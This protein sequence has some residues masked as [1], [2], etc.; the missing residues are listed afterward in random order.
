MSK[1]YE[2]LQR[3]EQDR[4]AL[5]GTASAETPAPAPAIPAQSSDPEALYQSQT[6]PA[7]QPAAAGVHTAALPV[8]APS[9]IQAHPQ[10]V[11][12][13]I[14][15]DIVPTP[16]TPQL[17]KLPALRERG[18][19]VE[20][21]RS[22]RTRL[23]AF[24]DLNKLK[25]I[26]IGSGL[27]REGKSFIA[28]N[29]AVS[30]ARHKATRV[31]LIDGD[32]R[33]SSLH[34]LFGCERTPGLST[35]LAGRAE[36]Q[37]IMQRMQLPANVPPTSPVAAGLG[38]LT[39]IA[40]GDEGD[41]AADLSGSKRF[42]E[43]IDR[44]SEYFDW[45]VVDSSPVNLVTDGVNLAHACDAVLLVARGGVTRFEAAQRALGE[46]KS[47]KILGVVLNAADNSSKG[48]G[49]DGYEGYATYNAYD[50]DI[51]ETMRETQETGQVAQ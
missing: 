21:F 11:S 10:A 48:Y 19:A 39:F 22:L 16:W 34:T 37:D 8:V 5:N 17:D 6:E 18:P 20:Q 36:M 29:L 28:A 49:Y 7:F 14:F 4:L 30:F 43:L 33:R 31:L 50:S 23:F 25:S 41:K 47:S 1:I 40:G 44:A 15:A 13:R 24:R 3:A 2:A 45:I 38:S 51:D 35:Y 12:S 46:L 32:M 27:P 42:Q 9:T 26:M